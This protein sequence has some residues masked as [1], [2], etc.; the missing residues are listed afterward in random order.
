LGLVASV[1]AV[2]DIYLLFPTYS[3]LVLAL[4]VSL[5]A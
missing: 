1:V 5:T 3:R 4:F 2:L